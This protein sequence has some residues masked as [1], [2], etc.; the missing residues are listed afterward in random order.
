MIIHVFYKHYNYAYIHPRHFCRGNKPIFGFV[1]WAESILGQ[2]QDAAVGEDSPNPGDKFPG[3]TQV[4]PVAVPTFGG[5]GV[6]P[7]GGS[8]PFQW[9]YTTP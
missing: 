4:F 1:E 8:G 7:Y 9:S 5:A 2:H 6:S 3:H